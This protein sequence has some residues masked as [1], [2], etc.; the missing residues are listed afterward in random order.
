MLLFH[1]WFYG[2]LSEIFLVS[3]IVTIFHIDC[4]KCIEMTKHITR[5]I[6]CF[7][8]GANAIVKQE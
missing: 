8:A 5:N 4:D 1:V 6:P 7:R 3:K 2:I